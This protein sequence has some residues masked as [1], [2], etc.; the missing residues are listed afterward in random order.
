MSVNYTVRHQIM[1]RAAPKHSY[2][3]KA[4]T[5]PAIMQTKILI[6][7]VPKPIH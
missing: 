1:N 4:K 3:T 6:N 7:L 2:S 5:K